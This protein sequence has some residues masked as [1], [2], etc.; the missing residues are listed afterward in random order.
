MGLA[1]RAVIKDAGGE[2]VLHPIQGDAARAS[3]VPCDG[4]RNEGCDEGN[5]R[6]LDV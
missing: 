1:H 4:L 3:F 2:M 5:E 6:Q